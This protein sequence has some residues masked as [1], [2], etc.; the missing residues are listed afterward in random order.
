MLILTFPEMETYDPDKNEFVI[1]PEETCKFMFNLIA[2]D[3]WE[4]KN[5]KRFLENPDLTLDEYL[6]FF[7]VMCIEGNFDKNRVGKLEYEKLIEYLKLT[8]S[9][10]TLP[11]TSN[12]PG[13]RRKELTS[14]IIYAY[15][16]LSGIPIEWENRNLNK[17]IV[18]IGTIS[19]LQEPPK[20]MSKRE[21]MEEQA[22]LIRERRRKIESNR[23]GKL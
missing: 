23:N 10:T 19:A 4:S 22:K 14:E 13:E 8:P 6:D 21:A 18:L 11:K 1:I 16:C 9:A 3:K 20:K 5:Q 15:M 12:K 17:L 7:S 2:V